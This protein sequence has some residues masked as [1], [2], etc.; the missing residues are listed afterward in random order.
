MNRT[1]KITQHRHHKNVEL[2]LSLLITLVA[3]V[4]PL[5]YGVAWVVERLWRI[6][7]G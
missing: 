4:W 7:N 1:I 5:A 3:G 2:P 6:I